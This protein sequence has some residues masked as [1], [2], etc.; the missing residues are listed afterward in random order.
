MRISRRALT[1]GGSVLGVAAV[2]GG[3]LV[4][5]LATMPSSAQM[6]DDPASITRV[7]VTPSPTTTP[8]SAPAAPAPAEVPSAPPAQEV[9]VV[10][11]PAPVYEPEPVEEPPVEWVPAGDPENANGGEWDISQCPNGASTGPDGAPVCD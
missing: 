10:E 3:L 5:G 11:A 9:P 2:A 7:L 6:D 4:F 8:T 1:V